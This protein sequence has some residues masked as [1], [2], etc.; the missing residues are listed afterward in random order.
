LLL[1]GSK[2]GEDFLVRGCGGRPAAAEGTETF[3]GSLGTTEPTKVVALC[4]N[5]RTYPIA[6]TLLAIGFG[7]LGKID[8]WAKCRCC[9]LLP[10]TTT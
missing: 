6:H 7:Q 10:P 5:Q 9:R 8:P 1:D 3:S 4:Y 2:V